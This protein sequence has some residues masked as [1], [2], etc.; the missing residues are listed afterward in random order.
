VTKAQ[1]ENDRLQAENDQL[2]CLIAKSDMDCIYCG[3]PKARMAWCASG[4]PGCGRA[5]DLIYGEVNNER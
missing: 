4:F 1:R 3:L 5:D 2:R